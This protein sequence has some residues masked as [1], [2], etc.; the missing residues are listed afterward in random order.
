M[1]AKY[2]QNLRF[3]NFQEGVGLFLGILSVAIFGTIL[4]YT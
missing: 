1:A 3:H 2:F 4:N